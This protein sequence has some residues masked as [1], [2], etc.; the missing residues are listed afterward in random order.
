[1]FRKIAVSLLPTLLF[2]GLG[3]PALAQRL[4]K[5]I[6]S[7]SFNESR[8]ERLPRNTHA[9]ARSE[10]DRGL[11]PANLPMNHMLMVLTPSPDRQQALALLLQAQQDK[12]SSQYHRWLTPQEFGARFGTAPSDI[13]TVSAWLQ[14]NGFQV[15][16]VSNGRNLVEF[17]GTAGQIQQAFHTEIH[18]F[19]VNGVAHWANS[20]DPEIPAALTPVVA[21]I[22]TLYNFRKKSQMSRVARDVA[23]AQAGSARQPQFTSSTG[24]HAL[25]PADFK[26]VYNMSGIPK[27]LDGTST[28]IAV[29]ARSNINM[30]DVQDFKNAFGVPYQLPQ[31]V[32]NGTDPGNLGD[33]DEAE[34]VLDVSWAAGL[35]PGATVD[36]VVSA[37]T[38]T[39]DGVDLSEEYIIDN[40][41]ADVMTE[42]Y[43]ICEAYFTQAE[44]QFYSALAQQAAAQGI[45]YTVAA[46]DSGA[47]GCDDPNNQKI[48][49]R[50]NAVNVLAATPFNIAV[51]GTQLNET[52]GLSYWNSSNSQTGFSSFLGF[53][54]PEKA[55]NESCTAAQCGASAGIWAGGGGPSGLFSKPAW[56]SGV[57]GIP[58]D[59][60]RDV[61]DVSLTSAS[62]DFYLL[63]LDGSCTTQQGKSSFSGVSGTSAATPAFAA[64]MALVVQSQ[65]ARQ[66]Q[67]AATLYGLAAAQTPSS[68]NAANPVYQLGLS[69]DCIFNDVTTGN[70]AV[71]GGAGYGTSAALYQARTG[72]DLATGLGSVNVTN[73]VNRWNGAPAVPPRIRTEI[74]SPSALNSTVIGLTTFSGWALADPG[75]VVSVKISIDSVPYG[76]A[77][78]GTARPDV[79]AIYSGVDCPGVGWSFLVET[80]SLATGPH[81]MSATVSTDSGQVYTKS[82]NF[83]VAN[84]T[85]SNP[86]KLN[87]DTPSTSSPAFSGVAYLGGW[88]LSSLSAI[89]QLTVTVDG[90]SYG[91]AEYGGARPDVC[92]HYAG[93]PGCPSVGWNFALNT[94]ALADGVHTLAITSTTDGGQHSSISQ[95][96]TVANIPSNPITIAIDSP[97]AQG[98]ALTGGVGLGGWALSTTVPISSVAVSIDGLP[99][100]NAIYGG[101]REDACTHR[102]GRPSCPNVGWNFWLDTTQL[103]SGTHVLGITAYTAASQSS[104][105]TRNFT[106]VNAQAAN[107]MRV[108]IDLPNPENS[109]LLGSVTFTGW[110]VDLN[111]PVESVGISIDGAPYGTADYGSTRDDVCAVYAGAANC[112]NVGWSLSLDTSQLANGTH[113]LTVI[114]KAGALQSSV[115]ALFTVAN[116]TTANP[117]KLTIDS[118][119]SQSGPLSGH[120]GIGGWAIDQLSAL[121]TISVAVD[122]IALGTAEYGG[123]RSDVCSHFPN[124]IGCPNVG[125]NYF[126]DTTLLADGVHTL[127]LTGIT[128]SGRTSTFTTAFS[129]ANASSAP[130][131]VSIDTPNSTQALTG[132]APLGGWAVALGGPAVTT[133]QIFVDGVAVGSAIYD[134][135]RDDV[136]SRI[137]ASG[138]PNVGWNYQLDTTPFANGA[139]ALQV[140]ATASNGAVYTASKAFTIINRP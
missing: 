101:S 47:A 54:I 90:V 79:C 126:L 109:I 112:P 89:S 2:M 108:G 38:N 77:T 32:V 39:T 59:G 29:V 14:S 16:R 40:N 111:A 36:L 98:A 52:S 61:P 135:E 64:I 19:V 56:Q 136:C 124:A 6:L 130:L 121:S 94:S 140:R 49:R 122:G 138:C 117:M 139:H 43:G 15:S 127:A 28:T 72:Y 50:G 12:N 18:Q 76:N 57:P 88:A 119:N 23:S 83:T 33:G 30:Q 44:A 20:S 3:M 71:P 62:H 118:P 26:G 4:S 128:A 99:A 96:F 100:G 53:P 104:S 78:Y 22:S 8:F 27:N 11:A 91:A 87:I 10:F 9:L 55:W 137:S 63:C 13:D 1:M 75:S 93:Y 114:P 21:G 84:W 48:A 123:N 125:W 134:G 92:K 51:G 58:A 81:T 132:I 68:C 97:A 129:V 35:A 74:D 7:G 115:S 131:R 86:I 106:V 37:S 120:V 80:T 105:A 41:L 34:A 17:S 66:G 42:S 45:T 133:V 85:A 113:I 65:N 95:S 70:N 25:S 31:I 5:G 73:L 82:S 116:W 107:P 46:G 60:A 67:A 110:A 24:I 102:P 69:T 103:L